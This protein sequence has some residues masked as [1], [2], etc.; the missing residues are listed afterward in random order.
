VRHS[1]LS[2]AIC[3]SIAVWPASVT[4]SRSCG[5]EDPGG[6]NTS[7]GV[8]NWIYPNALYVTSAVWK[9][10]L[11]GVI[12]KSRPPDQRVRSLLGGYAEAARVLR[13]FGQN[14]SEFQT[15]SSQPSISLVLLG[16][17]LW[18]RYAASE[19]GYTTE[20]H[21]KGASAGDVVLVTDEP[22]VEALVEGRL[23][24]DA[25]EKRGLIRF[26]GRQPDIVTVR[27]FLLQAYKVSV[28]KSD[29]SS[30]GKL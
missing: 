5:F 17:V 29:P 26:Y 6:V 18:T 24:A 9:A 12:A 20:I 16:P 27:S 28:R 3:L 15:I 19:N 22:V 4:P 8:L 7:R 2:I 10:Q 30:E 11:D 13:R 1:R 25:A 23:T 14:V 21:A